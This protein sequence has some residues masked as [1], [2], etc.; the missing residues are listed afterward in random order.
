MEAN[1][2]GGGKAE[3]R[4]IVA[5]V[6]AVSLILRKEKPVFFQLLGG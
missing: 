3:R 1:C 5:T 2:V 6:T 4:V